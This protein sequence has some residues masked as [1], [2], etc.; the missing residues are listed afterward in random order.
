MLAP[1]FTV[2]PAM[3]DYPKTAHVTRAKFDTLVNHDILLCPPA[4]T[5]FV[6]ILP[7][8]NAAILF[9]RYNMKK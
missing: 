3:A 2:P 6:I 1:G 5:V 8:D 7:G 4:F 9:P